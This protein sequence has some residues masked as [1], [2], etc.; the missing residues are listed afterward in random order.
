MRKTWVDIITELGFR[1]GYIVA[2]RKVESLCDSCRGTRACNRCEIDYAE[3]LISEL[4]EQG[5]IKA[6]VD[7]S[8]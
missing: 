2:Q 7:P 5:T 1:K 4:Y 6:S 3:T 8:S